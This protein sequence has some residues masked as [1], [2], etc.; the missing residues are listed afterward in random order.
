MQT[1]KVM[2]RW[3]LWDEERFHKL[4]CLLKNIFL[5]KSRFD[6]SYYCGFHM[7]P[8]IGWSTCEKKQWI[9]PYAYLFH[10]EANFSCVLLYIII[11]KQRKTYSKEKF[12]WGKAK[13]KT[14]T[15]TLFWI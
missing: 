9:F 13:R 2:E 8:S 10:L 12:L 7:G 15:H 5:I 1:K 6:Q 4:H 11:A 14:H 3:G